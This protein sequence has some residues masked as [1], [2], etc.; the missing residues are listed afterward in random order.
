MRTKIKICGFKTPDEVKH[1][2]PAEVD[3]MGIV[4]FFRKAEGPYPSSRQKKSL[5]PCLRESKRRLSLSRRL[6]NR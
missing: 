4:L 1:L 6:R 3:F 2:K 5:R